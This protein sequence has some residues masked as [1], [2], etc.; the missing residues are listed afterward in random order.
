MQADPLYRHNGNRFVVRLPFA[1]TGRTTVKGC[2][3]TCVGFDGIVKYITQFKRSA[4]VWRYIHYV[5]VQAF[6][7]DNTQCKML[8]SSNGEFT[9]RMPNARGKSGVST[10]GGPEMDEPLEQFALRVVARLHERCPEA[11]TEKVLRVDFFQD[12]TSGV[13][14]VNKVTLYFYHDIHLTY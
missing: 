5:V 7:S 14:L 6:V 1:P 3:G 10:I 13:Y 11:I 4:K 8:V 2:S 9:L 12:S